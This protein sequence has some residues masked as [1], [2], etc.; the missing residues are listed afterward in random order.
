MSVQTGT[1]RKEGGFAETVRVVFHALIIARRHPDL[2]VS[3][4]Q[5]SF[6]LDDPDPPGRRLSVRLQ[7]FL[8]LHALFVA[9]LA[10]I[11][12]RAGF[13]ASRTPQRGDVVVFRLPKDDI[14]R[15]HQARDRVARRPHPDD[16]RRAQHQ[17]H[18]GQARA[19]RRLRHRR[20][21]RRAAR[22]ALSRDAAE[23][24]QLHDASISPTTASTTTRRSIPCRPATIS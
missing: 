12:S 7:I 23:R 5:Y 19:R 9:V 17:R 14:D 24:R 21:R 10:A 18:A 4:L 16:R 2:S 1:K 6:R 3:A 8:W 20:R 11:F 22:Q 13:S 15:L